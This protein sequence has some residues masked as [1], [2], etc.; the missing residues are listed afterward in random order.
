MEASD[1]A[2]GSKRPRVPGSSRVVQ[3]DITTGRVI[4]IHPNKETAAAAVGGLETFISTCLGG[5][6]D[7]AYGFGWRYPTV[8]EE[9]ELEA[10]QRAEERQ[11]QLAQDS[12]SNIQQNNSDAGIKQEGIYGGEDPR[13]IP[14][15]HN[16]LI[17]KMGHPSASVVDGVV[18]TVETVKKDDRSLEHSP[19]VIMEDDE[20]L[21]YLS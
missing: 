5:V 2:V 17:A 4:R 10:M 6:V 1:P 15:D 8:E 14:D 11:L 16:A 7:E 12:A 9:E 13:V 20:I 21:D 18:E 19:D 3:I